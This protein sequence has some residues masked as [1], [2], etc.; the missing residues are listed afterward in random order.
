LSL[1]LTASLPPSCGGPC[2]APRW[3][4]I[5]CRKA[6]QACQRPPCACPLEEGRAMR[7]ASGVSLAVTAS[8]PP[9][10]GRLCLGLCWQRIVCSKPATVRLA[11]D[12]KGPGGPRSALRKRRVTSSDHF[13]PALMWRAALC[14][15]LAAD[16][17]QQACHRPPCARPQGAGRALAAMRYASGV[18]L[19]V[20]ASLP[21]SCGGPRLAPSWRRIVCSKPAAVRLAPDPMRRAALCASSA[22]CH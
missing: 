15:A 19:A 3:R 4:R 7:Y 8:L 5:V 6:E 17:V 20:T 11:P 22:A 16:R 13:A 18:S 2:L 21:P 12:T 10:C 14:N 1:A 9:S